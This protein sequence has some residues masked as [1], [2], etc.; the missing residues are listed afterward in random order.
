MTWRRI[1]P[2]VEDTLAAACW[3]AGFAGFA[4]LLAGMGQ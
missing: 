3:I 4:L 1:R 2:W